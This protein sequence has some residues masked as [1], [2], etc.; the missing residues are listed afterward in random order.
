MAQPGN[1]TPILLYGS[2]TPTN[3]PLAANLTNSAT[4]SEI[5]INVADKN[6]FFKDSGGV[7]NTVPIRQS[8]ASSNGWLSSTDWSTF[9][10]KAPATSGTSILYGNGTGGFSNVTIGSGISFAGGTLSATGSGGTVTSVAALTIGTTGTD[11]SSTVANGTTTPVITLNVP[12]ASAANRGALSAADWSTFNGKQATLVSG[13]NLKTVNGTTLLGS[14]DLGTI[15]VAYGGTGLT[16]L[17]AGRIPYGQG[18]SALGNSA[19]LFWDGTNNRLGIGTS[20]PAYALDVQ[21]SATAIIRVQTTSTTAGGPAIVI[22]TSN[23]SDSTYKAIYGQTS[24]VTKWAIGMQGG[25]ATDGYIGLWAN[26]APGAPQAILFPSGGFSIGNTTD[27][28][29]G[30]LNVNAQLL[31]GCTSLPVSNRV[32]GFGA[33]DSSVG[34]IQVYQANS[35][36]DWAVNA[37]SGSIC[38]FY[39]DN[40]ALVYAGSISVNGN[41]TTYGSVSDYR[42]KENVTPVANA[43]AVVEK[44]NPVDFTW[45]GSNVKGQSFI[46]HELQELFPGAVMGQKDAVKDDGTPD[47]QNIDTSCLIATLVAAVKELKVE[48]DLLKAK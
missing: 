30:S 5:A 2:S 20:S 4:G 37:T 31:V 35:N 45:K 11:L 34:G 26:G 46:A 44:L 32:K 39:S 7:V 47:Y 24:G 48:L 29:A 16:S 38:N 40:G 19:N 3:V 13:T 1:F 41:V 8:S 12:T 23:T 17:T 33:K 14:G 22:N 6:L 27:P 10:N 28:G 25:Y 43:L 9:N 36:S 21:N 15:S 42:I 18:T